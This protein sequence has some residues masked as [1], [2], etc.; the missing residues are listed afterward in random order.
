MQRM[1]TIT[2][3]SPNIVKLHHSDDKDEAKVQFTGNGFCHPDS[4][5]LTVMVMNMLSV[6]LFCFACISN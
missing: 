2:Y 4:C 3:T 6:L 5:S 1:H